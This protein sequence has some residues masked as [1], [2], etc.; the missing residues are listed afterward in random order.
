YW[1]AAARAVAAEPLYRSEDGH[2]QFKY[3]PAFAVAAAPLSALPLPLAKATWLGL[4][5]ALLV[6]LLALSLRLLTDRRRPTWFLVA[7]MLVA[8][9]KFFGHELVLGQVN[10]LLGAIVAAA[11]HL[12]SSRHQIAAGLLFGLAVIVKPYAVIFF[13]WLAAIRSGRALLAGAAAVLA[14]LALPAT[15]YGMSGAW[16]LHVDWWQTVSASTAPNLLNADNV[17]LAAMYAKWMGPGRAAALLALATACVL[18]AAAAG[19]VLLR[20]RVAAP[21]G[22]E[23]AMLLTLIPLLSPQGWDYVFLAS[24]PAVMY[25][26]NYERG[27][28]GPLRLITIA[29]LALVAFSLYDVMGRRAYGMFMALS[30]ITVCYLVIVAALV[31]LRVRRVA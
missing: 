26:V 21:D 1:T 19:V 28:A 8:M 7:V 6:T 24:T 18:L 4:S 22:L 5:I 12:L 14:A 31:A 3:L 16:S 10:L 25:L 29:A 30:I 9:G 11:V 13:P 23:A 20:T 15:V 17:S 27:L 2:F